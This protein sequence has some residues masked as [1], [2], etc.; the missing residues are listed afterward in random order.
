MYNQNSYCPLSVFGSGLTIRLTMGL[1]MDLTMGLATGLCLGLA[2]APDLV[3]DPLGR[4]CGFGDKSVH[5]RL[6]CIQRGQG[7]SLEQA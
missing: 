7:R 6:F 1:T 3:L 2:M 4:P 5:V